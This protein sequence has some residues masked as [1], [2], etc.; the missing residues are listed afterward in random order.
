MARFRQPIQLAVLVAVLVP[1]FWCF[2]SVLTGD[3]LLAYRDSITFYYP[4]YL[5][6]SRLWSTGELPLWN[7][8]ANL[9]TPVISET[10]SAVLY[11]GKLLFALPLPDAT[12]F[13]LYVAG[14]FLISRGNRVHFSQ[15]M[16]RECAGVWI[17]CRLVY[18]RRWRDFPVL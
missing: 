4:N 5:W 2:G 13:N 3:R 6:I 11:P 18:V 15:E 7:P 8:Q 1:F 10:T 17:E 14:A 16:A 12:R 9:G